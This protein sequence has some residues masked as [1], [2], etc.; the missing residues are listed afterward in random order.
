MTNGC[1]LTGKIEMTLNITRRG[2][3]AFYTVC[4]LEVIDHLLLTFG[5]L[6]I[7]HNV[8]RNMG[9]YIGVVNIGV[10]NIGVV[11]IG[12][13]K[14]KGARRPNDVDNVTDTNDWVNSVLW[15]INP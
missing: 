8:D 13:L 15:N 11:N 5:K 10:V 6:D 14:P 12:L 7:G 9:L 3:V 4:F 1:R 2:H